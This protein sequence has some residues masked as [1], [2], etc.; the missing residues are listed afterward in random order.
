[1]KK[2]EKLKERRELIEEVGDFEFVT[3]AF[4]LQTADCRLER[5]HI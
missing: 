1:M 5:Y 2:I 4:R 3:R